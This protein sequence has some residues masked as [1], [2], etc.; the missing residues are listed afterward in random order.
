MAKISIITDTDSSLPEDMAAAYNIL[1]VPISIHMGDELSGTDHTITNDEL[2]AK[3]DAMGKLPTTAAPTPGIFFEYFKRVFS[4]HKPDTLI[5]YATVS[6]T[7]LR[8]HE[9]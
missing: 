6:Y 1:Q 5:Y 2:F 9:T 3:V 7:H 4:E 8:A